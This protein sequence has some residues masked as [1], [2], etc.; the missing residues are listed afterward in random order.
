MILQ[1]AHHLAGVYRAR[2]VADVEVRVRAEASLNSRPRQ[3]L[4]DPTVDLAAVAPSIG[5]SPWIVPLEP[6][7]RDS[8]G[9]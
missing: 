1:Y 3:L 5:P 4:I 6:L 2:G 7:V 9:D 8:S